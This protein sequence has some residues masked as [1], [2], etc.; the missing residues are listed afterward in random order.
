MATMQVDGIHWHPASRYRA[1]VDG[2]GSGIA[3]SGTIFVIGPDSLEHSASADMSTPTTV[4]PGNATG[5]I[6]TRR[7]LRSTGSNGFTQLLFSSTGGPNPVSD[8]MV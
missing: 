1:I 5:A 8:V 2:G 7:Y 4:A 6:S 3:G